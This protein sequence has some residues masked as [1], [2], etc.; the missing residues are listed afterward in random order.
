M[1]QINKSKIEKGATH[2]SPLLTA[3]GLNFF[4]TLDVWGLIFVKVNKKCKYLSKNMTVTFFNTWNLTEK[5][6]ISFSIHHLS[7][8]NS[9][10]VFIRMNK[11]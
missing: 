7:L 1:I 10:A 2:P 11:Q 5:R 8:Q 9:C 4:L 6:H 3:I